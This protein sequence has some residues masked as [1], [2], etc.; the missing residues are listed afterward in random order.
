MHACMNEMTRKEEKRKANIRT[1]IGFTVRLFID[2]HPVQELQSCGAVTHTP[3]I[4]R[5]VSRAVRGVL[6]PRLRA[7]GSA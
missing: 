3:K 4:S 2:V 7:V 1:C 5:L 6:A